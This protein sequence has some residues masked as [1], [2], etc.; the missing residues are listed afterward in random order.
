MRIFVQLYV[1]ESFSFEDYEW[2]IHN[3]MVHLLVEF[4]HSF[5]SALLETFDSDPS[6]VSFVIAEMLEVTLNLRVCLQKDFS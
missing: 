1:S 6:S 4:L 2:N 5:A 3:L